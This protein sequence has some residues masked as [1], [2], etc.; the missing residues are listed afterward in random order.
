MNST[1]ADQNEI[2]ELLVIGNLL[3]AYL[4]LVILVFGTIGNI[5]NV[6]SFA[7][8]ESLKTLASSLFLLASFIGSQCVLTFGLLTRVISGFSGIDP[9]NTS[10]SICKA[11]WFIRTTGGAVSLTCVC[12]AAIDRYFL[13]CYNVRRH[14]WITIKRARWAIFFSICFWSSVFSSYA[15]YYTIPTNSS[16]TIADPIFAYFASC[17]NL[18]HYSILPLSI[19]TIFCLL[20][21]RNLG[22]QPATYLRGG[23][24]LYDQVTRML[25]AQSIGICLTSFPNMIWQIYSVSST[26]ITKNSL[27]AAQ[28]NLINTICVLVGFSTHAITFYVY[29]IASSTF[30]KNVKEMFL[31]TR[32]IIPLAN[33]DVVKIT[34]AHDDRRVTLP[35]P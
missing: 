19:L 9:V 3:F 17:F 30:R 29:L 15:V 18:L 14:R 33:L 20:T 32:R 13:S 4:G 6:I 2:Q 25:I 5:I 10:I 28:E 1:V 12:L 21:W 8:L 7:R 35:I 24:R 34:I 31:R 26:S 22:Q 16:C 23:V 11:R 27:R